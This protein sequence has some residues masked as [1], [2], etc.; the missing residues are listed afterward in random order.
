MSSITFPTDRLK[1]PELLQ[2]FDEEPHD[3]QHSDDLQAI[4]SQHLE[5]PPSVIAHHCAGE[6]P[7]IRPGRVRPQKQVAE[8]TCGL[9]LTFRKLSFSSDVYS[10]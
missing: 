7:W 6:L 3:H 4:Q 2:D 10:L 5:R 1:H 8:P 9:C